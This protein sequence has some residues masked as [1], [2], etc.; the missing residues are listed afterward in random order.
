L[1]PRGGVKLLPEDLLDVADLVPNGAF[2]L[3]DGAAV[4]RL[5]LPVALPAFSF[6]T[7]FACS[8]R[9]LILS[10]VLDFMYS[11]RGSATRRLPSIT[12]DA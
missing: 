5:V 12:A 7:P 2:H 3:V 8:V 1:A 4:L 10:F 6:K 11:I 9:P